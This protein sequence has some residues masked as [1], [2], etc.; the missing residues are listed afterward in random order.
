MF[1]KEYVDK[2]ERDI[3]YDTAISEGYILMEEQNITEGN[4]LIFGNV[5]EVPKPEEL[6]PTEL[7][8]LQQKFAEQEVIIQELVFEI[9]PSLQ[10]GI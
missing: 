4:F 2:I 5:D 7:E 8:L 10:G 1:K 6:K 3:I 9:I